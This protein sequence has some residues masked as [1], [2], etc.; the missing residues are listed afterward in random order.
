LSVESNTT[1]TKVKQTRL[2]PE[3]SALTCG[4]LASEPTRTARKG[5]LSTF[6][7]CFV[8]TCP[9]VSFGARNVEAGCYYSLPSF[10]HSL[11]VGKGPL[12]APQRRIARATGRHGTHWSH[13]MQL[14]GGSPPHLEAPPKPNDDVWFGRETAPGETGR[15]ECLGKERTKT[16]WNEG[17]LASGAEA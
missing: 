3:G 12:P 14:Q 10:R 11:F 5:Q 9:L 2:Q 17:Q 15:A 4:Q 7:I 16:R 6:F 8:S 13:W 1:S